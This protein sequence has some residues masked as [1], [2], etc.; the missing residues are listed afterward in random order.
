MMGTNFKFFGFF[1]LFIF[2]TIAGAFNTPGGSWSEFTKI[3]FVQAAS[4]GISNGH[5]FI[6]V[7]D[8]GALTDPA[9]CGVTNAGV[10]MDDEDPAYDRI[11]SLAMTAMT[12]SLPVQIQVGDVTGAQNC[13]SGWRVIRA[14][15]VGAN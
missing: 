9:G 13:L 11:Q 10:R 8:P 3:T 4:K 1:C 6:M 15:N 14:I 2:P 5:L 12:A 7:D